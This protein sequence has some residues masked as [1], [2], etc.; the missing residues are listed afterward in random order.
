M[1]CSIPASLASS[2]TY[3]ISG[4]VDDGQHFLRH[5]LGGGQDAG[6][7]AGDREDG[8]ADFS[9]GYKKAWRERD[10]KLLFEHDL[11]GK[12]VST[13]PDHALIAPW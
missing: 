1:K 3:W 10:L 4:F 13:F 8:F 5:R 12:P 9:C 11:F 7:E 2:A 6:A